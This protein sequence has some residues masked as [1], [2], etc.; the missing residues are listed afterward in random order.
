MLKKK[1][2]T[3]NYF[4][5]TK[6]KCIRIRCMVTITENYK[7]VYYNN[8]QEDMIKNIIYKRMTRLF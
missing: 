6:F 7:Y 1:N 3:S 4:F 2:Y 8:Y 5:I